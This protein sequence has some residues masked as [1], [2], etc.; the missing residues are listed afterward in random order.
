M[1]LSNFVGSVIV[2]DMSDEEKVFVDKLH[3]LANPQKFD[4]REK[5]D[6]VVRDVF[7]EHPGEVFDRRDIVTMVKEAKSVL[8]QD[9]SEN[10]KEVADD[11][12][13]N[14]LAKSKEYHTV[15]LAAATCDAIEEATG[16]IVDPVAVIG[17]FDLS[18]D[19]LSLAECLS[20][21]KD[22][23]SPLSETEDDSDSDDYG[24]DDDDEDY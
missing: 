2:S 12:E 3:E 15:A 14:A 13:N 21:E 18:N 7:D 23:D 24:F 4:S 16:E 22:Y 17:P 19:A 9:I 6:E 10:L 8:P 5:Y 1:K 20:T 11:V